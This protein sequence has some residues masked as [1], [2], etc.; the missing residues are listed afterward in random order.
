[1][2]PILANYHTHTSRCHH[3]SGEDADYVEAALKEGYQ[4]LGFSDHSPWPFSSGFI[5]H[6]RM[7][8][9]ALDDYIF[10]IRRLQKVYEGRIRIHLG[11]EAEYFPRY[12]DWLL[13]MQD[14]GISYY[15][16]GQHYADSEE[17]TPYTGNECVE[18]KGV[19][20]YA[21]STVK[22]VRTGLFAYL[23]HPDLFM[24]HRTDDQFNAAC[25]QA[26]DMICQACL[27]MHLPIE[28]NLLGLRYQVEGHSRGYPSSPFWERAR[29]FGNE[30]ILGMDAHT[31]DQLIGA[32]LRAQAR[33][34]LHH[35]GYTIIDR[36][37]MDSRI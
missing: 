6:I 16:L 25:E 22:A 10:S 12:H 20:R 37:P 3:A 19:L 2:S 21:E 18:D 8:A 29:S 28:Y 9:E 15:V 13:R 27:E 35:L 26:T 34:T 23:A 33:E 17:D 1:M 32:E 11:L 4:V 14:R 24:R 36:L 7:S 5:S 30:V 31:P